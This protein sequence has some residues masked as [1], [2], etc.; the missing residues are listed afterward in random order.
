MKLVI[1]LLSLG[2]IAI[3]PG[4]AKSVANKM[5]LDQGYAAGSLEFNSCTG[6]LRTQWKNEA[7]QDI[8]DSLIIGALV[9]GANPPMEPL[10]SVQRASPVPRVAAPSSSQRQASMRI[11]PDGSY[12]YGTDCRI[13]PNGQY[14]P[15]NPTIAPNGQYVTGRPQIAPDG[16]YVGGNGPVRMCPDGSYVSGSR[17][18]MTPNGRYVGAP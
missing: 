15:G 4:C 6:N 9:A 18:V 17:C 5:C 3:L 10:P 11:C 8:A 13:A 14:L 7:R 2:F 1:K 12:V 16:T